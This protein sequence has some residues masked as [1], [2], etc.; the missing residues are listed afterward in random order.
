MDVIGICQL[1][2]IIALPSRIT[3]VLRCR[4]TGVFAA[5]IK[6]VAGP[7]AGSIAVAAETAAEQPAAVIAALAIGSWTFRG[8]VHGYDRA[9]AFKHVGRRSFR[10]DSV[11]PKNAL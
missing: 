1:I 9:N 7:V 11:E 10:P 2:V 3:V 4:S 5:A 8:I 6:H